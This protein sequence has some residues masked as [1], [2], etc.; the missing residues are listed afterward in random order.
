MLASPL[1]A[2]LGDAARIAHKV[3]RSGIRR[4]DVGKGEGQSWSLR[5]TA[6]F[7]RLRG[8][9]GT[10]PE[11]MYNKSS[12]L[13][14]PWAYPVTLE[15][16]S[17]NHVILHFDER[18][19]FDIIASFVGIGV[20]RIHL[21][22]PPAWYEFFYRALRSAHQQ[23][24]FA[25]RTRV[26]IIDPMDYAA[27]TF[28]YME[29]IFEDFEIKT[30]EKLRSFSIEGEKITQVATCIS[31]LSNLYKYVAAIDLALSTDIDL[32]LIRRSIAFLSSKAKTSDSIIRLAAL[33]A[34][35]SNYRS[36]KVASFVIPS[37]RVESDL[38][39]VRDIMKM[40]LFEK[41]SRSMHRLGAVGEII[42]AIG[43]A[44]I[45][46]RALLK[47]QMLRKLVKWAYTPFM[48]WLKPQLG[49][50]DLPTPPL[51]LIQMLFRKKF[52]PPLINLS[53]PLAQARLNFESRYKLT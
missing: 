26:S 21:L 50:A 38:R 15:P 25:I 35:F 32:P 41:Y 45:Y 14:V 28:R 16:T 5:R 2:Q 20:S 24:P 9:Q 1:I 30:D 12:G 53:K 39:V 10:G 19:L 40:D 23:L 52:A 13:L 7:Q 33:K 11:H 49:I 43:Q 6:P 18:M 17:D 47:H 27:T 42:P 48:L 44:E 37:S 22:P 34:L 8:N 36:T 4:I 29:P 51:E 3:L 31:G 46:L